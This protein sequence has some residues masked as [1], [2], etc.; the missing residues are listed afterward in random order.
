MDGTSGV[1]GVTLGADRALFDGKSPGEAFEIAQKYGSPEPLASQD[2]ADAFEEYVRD[3]PLECSR[4][5]AELDSAHPRIQR[6][7]F[8]GLH[9]AVKD[10]G[11]IGW[12]GVLSLC[13]GVVARWF[14]AQ[15]RAGLETQDHG[16]LLPLFR[17]AEEGF[18]RNSL[19]YGLRKE[20]WGVLEDLVRIGAADGEYG[21]YPGGTGALTVSLNNLNGASFRAV[22][23]YAAWCRTHD[24]SR[25]MVSEAKRTFD[26]YL[27]GDNHTVSRHAVLGLFLPDLYYLDKEWARRLPQRITP[28]AKTGL[29]FWDGY[30]SGKQMYSYTFEDLWEWY[31]EFMNGAIPQCPDL[32][33][34]REATTKHVMLAY[35]YDLEHADGIVERLFERSYP[36]ALRL[37]VQQ[38]AHILAGKLDDPNFNKSKLAGLWKRPSLKSHNLDMWFVNTPLDDEEAIT[39][40]LDHIRQ[41]AGRIDATC[42]PVFKL[43]EYVAEFPLQVAEC[44]TVLMPKHA[45]SVV[46]DQA[47]EILNTLHESKDLRVKAICKKIDQ[48]LGQL[49]PHV[50]GAERAA[51]AS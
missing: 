29:A 5:A 48:M 8:L 41:Y 43:A 16:Q 4:K 30:V 26:E 3:N 19:D 13:R 36:P 1:V 24:K 44:L 50:N 51:R 25:T 35:F 17:L 32:V 33:R 14:E 12:N 42:N 27:D 49:P 37:C 23:Q 11:R 47:H 18:K 9:D 28:H 2:A 22:Y 38:T 40:Y 46:P 10:G 6:S 7:L 21:E 20:A 39:L 45:G 34:P 15:K 31:D